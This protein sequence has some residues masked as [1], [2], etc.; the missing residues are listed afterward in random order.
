MERKNEKKMRD[1]KDIEKGM[2]LFPP[3]V[4]NPDP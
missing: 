4:N 3:Q 2:C 1:E